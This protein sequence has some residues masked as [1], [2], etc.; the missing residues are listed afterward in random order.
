[1]KNKFIWFTA[2]VAA[3]LMAAC[4]DNDDNNI[5]YE[6]EVIQN[7]VTALS[8]N[9]GSEG[10]VLS[11]VGATAKVSVTAAPADAGN[12]DRIHYVFTSSNSNVFTVD[13]SGNITATGPGEA[14]LS[15]IANNYADIKATCKVTVVGKRITSVTIA[16]ACKDTLL[17]CDPYS[18]AT[19]G[20][21]RCE[22]FPQVKIEPADAS[23]KTLKY[24]SSDQRVA[25][26]NA[27]G[28]I[29]AIG[30]GIATIRV[31]A[32]DGSGKY[33]ECTVRVGQYRQDFLDRSNWTITS[34]PWVR[35]TPEG[36]EDEYG[37]PPEN[38]IDD[39]SEDTRVGLLKQAA[40]GG[41]EDGIL[42][43]TLDLGSEQYF[44]YFYWEGGWTNG[45]GSVNNN[46]KANRINFLYGSNVSKEGP[47]DLLQTNITISTGVY[48]A[49]TTLTG[50]GGTPPPYK[51]RY[52]RVE[53]RPYST[54]TTNNAI[55]ILWRDF[56]LGYRELLLP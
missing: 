44:N 56:K 45:S 41:P 20:F 50:S 10:V 47:F 37:G 14:F 43:F 9:V 33:D 42:F 23:V 17:T 22:L 51:Y 28:Q 25:Y 35:F 31:E 2:C 40:P 13:N 53:L 4:N 26:V 8:V 52:V 7:P 19:T 3:W 21:Q 18:T 46:V 38:L 11:D 6:E 49:T 48:S 39:N 24:S 12:I 5:G 15:I 30:L 27:D 29:V 34:S 32:I 1:M 16:E 55:A 54:A 36:T